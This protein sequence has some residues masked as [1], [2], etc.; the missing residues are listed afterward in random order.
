MA[1]SSR[2][3]F[4]QRG[5][6]PGADYDDDPDATV[7]RFDSSDMSD[8]GDRVARLCRP[9][10]VRGRGGSGCSVVAVWRDPDCI[11]HRH[12]RRTNDALSGALTQ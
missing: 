5:P 7:V 3:F 10:T 8:H 6:E 2:L 4:G 1:G 12:G 11:E 9:W